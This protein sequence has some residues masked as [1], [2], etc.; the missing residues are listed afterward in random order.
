MGG[1]LAA[2]SAVS[3][4]V[5]NAFCAI[6]PPGHHA[7]NTGEEEGFCFYSNAAIAAKYAQSVFGH[8]KILIIDWDYHHYHHG[9]GT[10]IS[11]ERLSEDAV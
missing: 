8:E 9:N 5:R 2:V 11:T 3:Q 7:N 1:A 4:G 10:Q 6:R